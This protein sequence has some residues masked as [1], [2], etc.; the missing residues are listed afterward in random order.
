MLCGSFFCRFPLFLRDN[1]TPISPL[2]S[3]HSLYRCPSGA[4]RRGGGPAGR[5]LGCSKRDCSASRRSGG[6]ARHSTRPWSAGVP[7][8]AAPPRR[9]VDIRPSRRRLSK[10]S[11]PIGYFTN[12]V[13]I[14]SSFL[15]QR[16][17]F[18]S[19]MA[20]E[21]TKKASLAGKPFCVMCRK[22][23]LCYL[24]TIF[25]VLPLAC[26]MMLTPRCGAVRRLPST[27]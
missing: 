6:A 12:V 7:W 10:F 9:L 21:G 4:S 23:L 14:M 16:Y 17:A 15:R 20:K 5:R 18:Y 25:S 1:M 26:R 24:T 3:C 27:E 13:S 11:T 2:V 8:P 19:K 22:A